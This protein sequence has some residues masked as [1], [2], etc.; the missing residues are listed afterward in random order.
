MF[1]AI[2]GSAFGGKIPIYPFCKSE[3]G[4]CITYS[5]P[6]IYRSYPIHHKSCSSKLT[7]NGSKLTINGE[8]ALGGK[9]DYGLERRFRTP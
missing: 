3:K 9:R 7:I 6:H 5:I 4:A 8:F 2:G 1:S